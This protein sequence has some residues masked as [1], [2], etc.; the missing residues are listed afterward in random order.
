MET[1]VSSATK[2]VVIGDDQPTVLIGERI[3]PTGKKRMSE[4]L[5]S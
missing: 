3:N 1:R 2:E 4:A 5:K